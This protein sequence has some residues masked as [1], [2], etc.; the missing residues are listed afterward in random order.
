MGEC[1]LVRR[2][3]GHGY[4]LNP[5]ALPFA[6]K[7][8]YSSRRSNVSID[9]SYQCFKKGNCL[10]FIEMPMRLHDDFASGLGGRAFLYYDARAG[11]TTILENVQ[12]VSQ[13]SN[14]SNETYVEQ[15]GGFVTINADGYTINT[16]G[17]TRSGVSFAIPVL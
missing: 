9:S 14:T 15:Q 1:L 3:G 13:Y 12:Y 7:F 11:K 4:R 17:G 6:L 5:D 8:W 2:G 10:I 16:A